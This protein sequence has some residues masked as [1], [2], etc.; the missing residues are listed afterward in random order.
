MHEHIV[1]ASEKLPSKNATPLVKDDV[2]NVVENVVISM[3]KNV[4]K[5]R[6]EQLC[7]RW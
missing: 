6:G 3:V 2:K 7:Q 5:K 1:T 4:V